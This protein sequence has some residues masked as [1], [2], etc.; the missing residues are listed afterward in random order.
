MTVSVRRAKHAIRRAEAAVLHK[1]GL[2]ANVLRSARLAAAAAPPIGYLGFAGRGNAGDDA[3]LLAHR[4]SLPAVDLGLLPLEWERETLALLGGA[5]RRRLH[6]G[7]LVGGGT[8]VGR[9]AWRRRLDIAQGSSPAPVAFTGVGVE[10]PAFQGEMQHASRDELSRWTETLGSAAHLTVRGPLS[11]Q[12]LRDAGIEASYVSDPALLLGPDDAVET[13]VRPKLL[14][15]NIADPEDQYRGTGS[16]VFDASVA[17]VRTLLGSGWRV[18]LLPFT[19]KDLVLARSLRRALDG[20]VEILPDFAD[21]DRLLA[22]VAQCDV[23]VGQ[24]LHAVVLAAAVAVP[25]LAVDYRPKCR[26]FQLSIGRGEW[27][28]STLDIS[29]QL[30]V[31]QVTRLHE[32]RNDHARDIHGAVTK[33]RTALREGERTVARAL[34]A[35]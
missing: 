4:R 18:R 16:R 1:E 34:A 5:R 31:D 12:L 17:A 35:R 27:T 33:A 19:R 29:A 9:E 14:G 20:R 15:L 3:I 32:D 7:V 6:S 28:V 2:P 21:V 24:R 26:D 10:D 8:V 13:A 30:V 23:L 22:A 11:A 25:A